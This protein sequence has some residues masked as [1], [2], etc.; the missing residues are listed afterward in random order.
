VAAGPKGALLA[1]RPDAPI[2]GQKLI[3][4]VQKH[5]N[6]HK[7]RPDARLVAHGTWPDA[8]SRLAA[9]RKLLSDML[10]LRRAG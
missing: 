7:L 8:P 3:A 6:A 5:P 2:D 10:P 9:V 1:F 4:Y